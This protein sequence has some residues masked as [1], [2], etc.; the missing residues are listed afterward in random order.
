MTRIKRDWTTKDSDKVVGR[1]GRNTPSGRIGPINLAFKTSIKE[2]SP[3]R[4]FIPVILVV[5]RQVGNMEN[6]SAWAKGR[7]QICVV[8]S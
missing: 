7:L 3:A 6:F 1:D 2:K 8:P 4:N 5:V